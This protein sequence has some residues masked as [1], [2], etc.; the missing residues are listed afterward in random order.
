MSTQNSSVVCRVDIIFSKIRHL[1]LYYTYFFFLLIFLN[2]EE[3]KQSLVNTTTE[4]WK[5]QTFQANLNIIYNNAIYTML[6][7]CLVCNVLAVGV[8]CLC[9]FVCRLSSVLD[10]ILA[11]NL[12]RVME[13]IMNS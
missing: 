10:D 3:S 7:Q 5:S 1:H 8:V 6:P 4:N 12:N 11:M 2:F 13:N 9:L